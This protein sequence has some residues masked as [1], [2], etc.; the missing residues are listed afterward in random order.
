MPKREGTELTQRNEEEALTVADVTT[1]GTFTRAS[2]EVLAQRRIVRGRRRTT[3]PTSSTAAAAPA[4]T[5]AAANDEAPRNNNPFANLIIPT[6]KPEAAAAE[7][8][9]EEPT[10]PPRNNNPFANLIIPT[11]KPTT[12]ETAA[13]GKEE[14][15]LESKDAT[16]LEGEEVKS[17]NDQGVEGA[18]DDQTTTA[19]ASTGKRQ[20]TTKTTATTT[21]TT[22]LSSSAFPLAAT[23]GTTAPPPLFSFGSGRAAAGV[24]ATTPAFSFGSF[25]GGSTTT[26]GGGFGQAN[27]GFAAFGATAASSSSTGGFGSFGSTTATTKPGEDKDAAVEEPPSQDT[28]ILPETFQVQ[29][30]EEDEEVILGPIKCKIFKFVPATQSAVPSSEHNATKKIA[31]LS[32]VPPS[33]SDDENDKDKDDKDND[34]NKKKTAASNDKFTWK[35]YGTG[36]IKLLQHKITKNVRLLQR[37]GGTTIVLNERLSGQIVKLTTPSDQELR[38]QF[39]DS[40]QMVGI[41][42]AKENF[43]TFLAAVR[44]HVVVT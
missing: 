9:E 43:A 4:V 39:C 35:P 31:P 8:K 19:T 37:N 14:E 22:S 7:G 29:T 44:P 11:K 20:K 17:S 34:D 5:A 40:C 27:K 10:A 6:K 16:K 15:E 21:T 1:D 42:V 13:E 18:K 38:L 3:N 26:F 23:N 28:K 25:G 30:G 2:A 41:K 32:S 36:E 24:A 12:A 33:K